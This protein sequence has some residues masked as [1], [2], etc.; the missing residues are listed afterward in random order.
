MERKRKS[1][2]SLLTQTLNNASNKN[3][4]H[5]ELCRAIVAAN[6]PFNALENTHFKGFL[7]KYCHRNIPSESTIRKNYVDSTYQGALCRIRSDI[8]D[9]HI[10]LSVDETT[11]SMGRYIAHL[12]VG[13]LNSDT[14]SKAHLICSR[15]LIK[16]NSET[17]AQFVNN[18]LKV[19]FPN[20]LDENKI[21]LIY[22]DAAAYMIAAVQLLKVFYPSVTHITCLAHGVN[23][24]AEQI[25]RSIQGSIN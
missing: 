5:S 16:T 19:L 22:T 6:I 1:K 11:D 24:V 12:I 20:S 7:E 2:Q 25:R 17:V 4:F 18:S 9:S 21:L 13:K 8:G 3:E 10:W 15:Q 23:R 14:P